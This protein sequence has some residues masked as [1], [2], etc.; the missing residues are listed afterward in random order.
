MK[1]TFGTSVCLTVMGESHGAY[2]GAVLDGLAPGIE[3]DEEK[4]RH[5]LTLR[6][7]AGKISTSRQEKDE[8]II[9]SGVFGGKTT[10]TPITLII[11][12]ADTR[13][14]DYS[15]NF[16]LARPGHADFTA[17]EKY[18]GFEDF[19]GGGHF[20]GRV[21]SALVAL[22]AIA[23]DALE[24]KGIF[25][26]THIKEI[27]GIPDA[28]FRD[29]RAEL[30]AI[31]NKTFPV[32]SEEAGEAMTKKIEEA[33]DAGDSVGGILETA[34]IGLPS[35]MGEPFFDSVESIISHMM[36]SVPGV[37][38]VLFGAGENFAKMRG[39]EANDPLRIENGRVY[40]TSNNNGGVNG[41]IT[42]GMPLVFS[43]IMKPTSS[44][45]RAQDTVDMYKKEN[46]TL[47]VAGRHDPCIVHRAGIVVTSLTAIAVCDML[48]GRYG[49]DGI[50]SAPWT[51]SEV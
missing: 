12:N 38:G 7:P 22:G 6:R 39:S 41:G 9:A 21:T 5:A 24:K 4:I 26:G 42:N 29:I 51:D 3:V 31:Y 35:G 33:A 10:G 23:R 36:F 49:T 32:I 16:G 20:S 48:A 15:K 11:P 13:S 46:A 25:I 40:T 43:C 34:V 8:Y 19:R 30:D 14:R 27:A 37:K 47:E 1:N 45:Y 44:I 17:H 50:V 28:P 18:H 2:I